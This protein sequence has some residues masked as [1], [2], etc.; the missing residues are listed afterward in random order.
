MQLGKI[1]TI[2]DFHK[3]AEQD[4]KE[5]E[6]DLSQYILMSS[7]EK[8]K[9]DI[10]IKIRNLEKYALKNNLPLSTETVL[11]YINASDKNEKDGAQ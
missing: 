4:L 1:K 2:E 3:P 9:L 7:V 8:C 11:K 6:V 10:K 5:F